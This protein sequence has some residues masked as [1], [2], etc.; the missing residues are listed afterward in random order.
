M[1]SAI[2]SGKDMRWR[3]EGYGEE[4]PALGTEAGW[5]GRLQT[6]EERQRVGF[7]GIV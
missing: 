2:E 1:G 5:E 7:I 3:R 4:V 6:Y